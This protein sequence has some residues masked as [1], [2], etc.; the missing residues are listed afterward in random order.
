M[1]KTPFPIPCTLCCSAQLCPTLHPV[2]AGSVLLQGQMPRSAHT[3]PSS[4]SMTP[5]AW[6]GL[7]HGNGCGLPPAVEE[8]NEELC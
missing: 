7:Q 2:P 3:V 4:S 6:A 5:Q 8:R 1:E